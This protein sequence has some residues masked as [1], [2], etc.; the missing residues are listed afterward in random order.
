MAKSALG[1]VY[2]WGWGGLGQLGQGTLES[3]LTPKRLAVFKEAATAKDSEATKRKALSI[4]AG[5]SHTVVLTEG[6]VPYW[7]GTCGTI[8]KQ[9]VAVRVNIEKKYPDLFPPKSVSQYSSSTGLPA[10]APAKIFVTWTKSMA[11]TCIGVLDMRSVPAA[12]ATGT[13]PSGNQGPTSASNVSTQLNVLSSKWSP[14][15][16]DPP[17][18]DTLAGVF[19]ASVMRKSAAASPGK[20]KPVARPSV[21]V[22]MRNSLRRGLARPQGEGE[23]EA[24]AREVELELQAALERDPEARSVDENM[25]IS[26]FVNKMSTGK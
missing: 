13:S 3:V 26:H 19:S 22:L 10:F 7:C 21:Q 4:A 12:P 11:L 23:V 14:E 8:T 9:A 6:R 2:T 20:R 17:Y 24:K 5:Y 16:I 15:D 25:M 1:K 18:L